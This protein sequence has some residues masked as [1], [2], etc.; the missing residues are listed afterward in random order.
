MKLICLKIF[1][2]CNLLV[3]GFCVSA[4]AQNSAAATISTDSVI[5]I[6]T[7]KLISLSIRVNAGDEAFK[8]QITPILPSGFGLV[9]D[10]PIKVNVAKN[11]HTFYPFRFLVLQNA[12]IKISQMSFQLEDNTGKVVAM[13]KAKVNMLPQRAVELSILSP[14]V[15]LKQVGDSLNVKVMVRNAGNQIEVLK[16]V[17]S[18]PADNGQGKQMLQKDVQLSPGTSKEVQFAKIIN[19]DL[20]QMGNFYINVAG[21]YQNGELFGNGICHV[22]N[23][24][25]NR[26]FVDAQVQQNI[27]NTGLDNHLSLSGQNLFSDSQSWQLNGL[28]ST[29][30]GNGVMGLSMD[31][32]QWNSIGN[33]PLLSNTWINYENKNA[34]ITAGNISENL[35]SFFNGRGVKVYSRNDDDHHR[36]EASMVQ[37][38]YNLLGDNLD[39]GYSAYVKTN[40]KDSSGREYSNTLIFDY[41]PLEQSRSLLSSN[42]VSLFNKR[43]LLMSVNL[44]GGLSQNLLDHTD[45]KPSLSLGTNFSGSYRKF[46]FSSNNFYSSGY[47]PGIRRGVIQLNER[48]SRYLGTQNIWAGFSYYSFNPAYQRN[49]FFFQ[50]EYA[51]QRA[52]IGWAR[53]LNTNLNITLTAS[54]DQESAIYNTINQQTSTMTAYRLNES[55]NWHST[56]FKQNVYLS[57]DNGISKG[58]DG[59]RKLQLRLNANWSGSWFNLSTYVQK[60]N[61]LLAEA[62]NGAVNQVDI[63]RYSVN[64]S[65]YKYFFSKKLRADAGLIYYHDGLYG[66]NLTYTV[67]GEYAITPKT[68]FYVSTYQ[69]RYNTSYFDSSF[70]SLQAGITQKLPTPK[71]QTP[72]KKGNL[73]IFFFKDNNHNGVFDAGEEAAHSGTLLI[74]GIIFIIPANGTIVYSKVPYGNYQLSMPMQD[75]YQISPLTVNVDQ[76]NSKISVPMQK[77]GNAVGKIA[78]AFNT[79]KSLQTDASLAGITLLVQSASG[80]IHTVKTGEDGEYSLHLP[81][82]AYQIYPDNSQLPENVYYDGKNAAIVVTAGK[83]ATIPTLTLKVREKKIEI[84]RFKN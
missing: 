8:G 67:K 10:Q 20:Y 69:Y 28:A 75:G 29:Q 81:E 18:F 3:L 59:E 74:N 27:V 42:S 83:E 45:I 37:K 53:P 78:I 72:G 35:E 26:Q 65:L 80:S 12:D 66:S 62:F 40:L 70:S 61:F 52:E 46:N 44:G 68:I 16:V 43:N 15:L 64:P 5:N 25:A 23:A 55:V 22:Q 7:E 60:G 48:I 4:Q 36:F 32:Y 82:G 31:A 49:T 1:F 63:Y 51:L 17:A 73:E 39:Y 24:S 9:S 84:K 38:S 58:L 6:G 14:S 54:R 2:Y 76:K 33:K 21:L 56:N 47:Y 41:A 57:L 11:E 13:F 71:Q 50:R 30:L 77:S 79:Q 34:G 19:R